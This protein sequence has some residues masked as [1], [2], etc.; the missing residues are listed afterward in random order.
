MEGRQMS[1]DDPTPMT[2]TVPST[3]TLFTN[4]NMVYE[5]LEM[6]ELAADNEAAEKAYD[7]L[8]RRES[9]NE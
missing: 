2:F 1:F 4:S 7:E 9:N 3:P 5:M 6:S 8:I